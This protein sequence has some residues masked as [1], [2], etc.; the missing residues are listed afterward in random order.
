MGPARDH[1][2]RIRGTSK[3]GETAPEDPAKTFSPDLSRLTDQELA[4]LEVIYTKLGAELAFGD[5]A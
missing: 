3:I 2:L 1:R 5:R 4:Q